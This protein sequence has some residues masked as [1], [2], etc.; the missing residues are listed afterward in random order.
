MGRGTPSWDD[1]AALAA[2]VLR[3]RLV[4]SFRAEAENLSTNDVIRRLLDDAS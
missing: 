1:I 2:P 3:H 4:L